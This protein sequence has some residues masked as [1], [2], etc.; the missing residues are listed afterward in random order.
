LVPSAQDEDE[1]TPSE[2]EE[3]QVAGLENR[4]AA[5]F[6][7]M[8]EPYLRCGSGSHICGRGSVI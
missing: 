7:Q 8:R 4:L 6:P 5:L 2:H 3:I 1:K